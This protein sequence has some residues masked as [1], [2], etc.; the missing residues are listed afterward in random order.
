MTEKSTGVLIGWRLGRGRC[1]A[2]VRGPGSR[3][4]GPGTGVRGTGRAEARPW[5]TFL[6]RAALSSPVSPGDLGSLG[7][8]APSAGTVVEC[9]ALCLHKGR[10]R[11]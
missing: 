2:G 7:A 10:H 4:R 11:A 6:A 1:Q 3:V 9:R 5:L 8:L